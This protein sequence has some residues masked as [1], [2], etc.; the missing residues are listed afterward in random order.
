VSWCGRHQTMIEFSTRLTGWSIIIKAA[1]ACTTFHPSTHLLLSSVERHVSCLYVARQPA[2]Q[3]PHRTPLSYSVYHPPA[4][5][6]G[7]C[8]A[9]LGSL[10]SQQKIAKFGIS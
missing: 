10:L 2:R 1:H 8:V 6:T 5:P 4:P 3:H 9:R 7:L